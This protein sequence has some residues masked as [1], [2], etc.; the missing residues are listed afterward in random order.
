MDNMSENDFLN[1]ISSFD[2]D[3]DRD[4][5]FKDEFNAE[6]NKKEFKYPEPTELRISTMTATCKTGLEVDL[7]TI[8]KYCTITDNDKEEEGI[9]KAEFGNEVR[10]ICKKDMD[11]KKGKKKKVF[12]NQ[13][14]L[15]LKVFSNNAIFKEVNMKIFTNGN[16]QMTGLKSEGDG[17]R[18]IKIFFKNT[19]NL[20]SIVHNKETHKMKSVSGVR[21]VEDFKIEDPNLEIVLINSD[22]STNFKIKREILH[23]LLIQKYSLFSSYEPC[24]YPGVNSKFFWNKKY[25]ND[26]LKKEGICHCSQQCIGKGKGD[27]YGKCK[28]ITISIFQSGN[29]IIT[30]ARSIEQINDAY[31]FINGILKENYNILKREDAPFFDLSE[32]DSEDE[33]KSLV[34]KKKNRKF[35]YLK[36]SNIK[37]DEQYQ[38]PSMS[39]P[40]NK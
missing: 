37:F 26:S 12:Y 15:I 31:N 2:L 9:I 14:T 19:K 35:V 23:N 6:L 20:T 24:I 3:S 39:L 22:F 34:I 21:N 16:L 13:A 8:F 29:I 28:K 36:K 18:A 10:G 11:N 40:I 7:N 38:F 17:K 30:G 32:S 5:E 4:N 25:R 33:S 27:G 1:I